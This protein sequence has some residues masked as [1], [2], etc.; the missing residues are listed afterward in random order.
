MN[1][2][3]RGKQAIVFLTLSYNSKYR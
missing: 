3:K 2:V 1:S